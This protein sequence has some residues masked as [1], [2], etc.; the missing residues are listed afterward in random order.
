MRIE[1]KKT[2]TIGEEQRET[3]KQGMIHVMMADD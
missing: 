1:E 3:S 2:T